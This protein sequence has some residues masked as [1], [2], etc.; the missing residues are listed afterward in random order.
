MDN[1]NVMCQAQQLL[2][3]NSPR[4][5][6]IS[7]LSAKALTN[8]LFQTSCSRMFAYHT[9]LKDTVSP[10]PGQRADLFS[11]QNN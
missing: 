3:E 11:E 7:T 4:M 6:L 5:A 10:S 9:P 1:F 8:I 2:E